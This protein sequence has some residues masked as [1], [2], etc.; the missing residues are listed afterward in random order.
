MARK[1]VKPYQNLPAKL[2]ADGVIATSGYSLWLNDLYADSGNVLFGG[3]DTAK[4]EGSLV[5]VPIQEV[6]GAYSQFFV[7]M[8]GLDIGSK[9]VASDAALAVLLDSGSSLTYLPNDMTSAIYQTVGATYSD[10][11]GV[12]FIPC[13]ARSQTANSSMTFR[14]SNPAS[15]TVTM[16]EMIL[17]LDDLTGKKLTFDNNVEACL[18]GIV[19]TGTSN[20]VLGDTFLRSAYVVYDL[21]SNEIGLANAK[22]N[23]TTSN[24]V[25]IQSGSIPSATKASNPVA[26]TNGLPFGS[27][28]GNTGGA[29]EKGS[30]VG[31]VMPPL[32][33]VL[34]GAAAGVALLF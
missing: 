26:A 5:S 15:V 28:G 23:V 33:A 8:T 1:G 10:A 2:A 27:G 17:D 29:S 16:S 4:F 22:Y 31:T 19:P 24:V 11:E 6:S 20:S 21:D 25:E 9:K 13:T 3:I 34:L 18:F 14:F 12:A 7:T 30:G 32:A